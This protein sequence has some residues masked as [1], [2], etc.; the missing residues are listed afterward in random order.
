VE[1]EAI[2]VLKVQGS[3]GLLLGLCPLQAA[4]G[5]CAKLNLGLADLAGQ[6]LHPAPYSVFG[7]GFS[8]WPLVQAAF[9]I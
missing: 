4:Q 2:G 9:G 1:E 8:A 5:L 6:A 7:T 3:T